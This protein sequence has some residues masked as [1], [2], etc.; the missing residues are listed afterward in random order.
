MNAGQQFCTFILGEHLFGIPVS[1]V[2]EVLLYQKMTRVPLAPYVVLGLMNL[3]GQI[4]AA[5]DLRR[6]LGMANRSPKHLP[7]NVVVRTGE[8]SVSLLVDDI[9]DV[10]EVE[11]DSFESPPQTVQGPVRDVLSGVY[12]LPGRLLLVLDIERVVQDL[13][14]GSPNPNFGSSQSRLNPGMQTG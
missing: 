11:Q 1:N 10:I 5:I 13:D 7:M 6:R 9:G 12:K 2:Q 4:V 8:G 3:R 14:G